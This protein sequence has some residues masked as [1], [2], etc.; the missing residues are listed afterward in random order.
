MVVKWDRMSIYSDPAFLK[1]RL[2]DSLTC[3][4]RAYLGDGSGL[5]VR[6][7]PIFLCCNANTSEVASRSGA[8]G[9]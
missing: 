3:L 9:K 6:V 8:F 1:V 2:A 7:P 4:D 5:E